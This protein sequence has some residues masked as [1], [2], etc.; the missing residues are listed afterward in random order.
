MACQKSDKCSCL[1]VVMCSSVVPQ[2]YS[3][4]TLVNNK[5][6][7]Y[8]FKIGLLNLDLPTKVRHLGTLALIPI[9][10]PRED[11]SSSNLR[12]ARRQLMAV[13]IKDILSTLREAS[14]SGLDIKLA[15]GSR[16][17]LFPR[18]LSWVA[19]DP[20][21]HAVLQIK[22]GKHSMRQCVR[23]FCLTQDLAAVDIVSQSRTLS[24]QRRIFNSIQQA[25]EAKRQAKRQRTGQPET[26]LRS[27][28]EISRL[29]GTHPDE[30]GLWGFDGEECD[31]CE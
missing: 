4:K 24:M 25:K 2:F 7:V 8:A 11:V 28:N 3:D 26:P 9:L 12:A 1:T 16:H 13:C 20:E 30:C 19:D 6:E 14:K 10:K 29:F 27:A 23:C 31:A 5:T 18:P 22:A 15:D 17:Q 21:Q